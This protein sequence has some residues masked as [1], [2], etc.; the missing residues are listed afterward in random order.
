L[1]EE[2]EEGEFYEEEYDEEEEEYEEDQELK[3][4]D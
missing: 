1:Y 4:E 2:P 3:I